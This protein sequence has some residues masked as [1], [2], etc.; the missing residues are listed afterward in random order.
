MK[1]FKVG[2]PVRVEREIP[3]TGKS[4]KLVPK[5][6]GPYRIVEVFDNDRYKI[7]DTP[8]T[9]KGITNFT[10]VFSVDKIYPWLVFNRNIDSDSAS[11]SETYE[12]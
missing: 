7:D 9:L 11:I 6:R 8:V 5:L 12:D 3:S 10:G 4:R 2:D 1:V